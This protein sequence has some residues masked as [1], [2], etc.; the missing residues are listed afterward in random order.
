MK[1]KL[2]HVTV[3]MYFLRVTVNTG[4]LLKTSGFLFL[5]V[6]AAENQ[7][8]FCF[9]L[10]IVFYL[11]RICIFICVYMYIYVECFGINDVVLIIKK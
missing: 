2:Y 4:K 3:A 1:L 6:R 5:F 10:V 9:V 11:T 7:A 8:Q